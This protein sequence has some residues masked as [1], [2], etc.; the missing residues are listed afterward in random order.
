MDN[1]VNSCYF[2]GQS[3]NSNSVIVSI[4]YKSKISPRSPNAL[5]KNDSNSLLKDEYPDL[6]KSVDNFIDLVKKTEL[7]DCYWYSTLRSGLSFTYYHICITFQ[8]KKTFNNW[9]G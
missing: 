2:S 5:N 7:V 3:E 8:V 9:G 6:Y 4:F 1:F